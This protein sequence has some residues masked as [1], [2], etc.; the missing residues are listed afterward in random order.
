MIYVYLEPV[1]AVLIAAALLGESLSW[2][3]AA[4]AVLAFMGVWL[5]S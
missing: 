2:I 3:Q 1:S 5:S 4:G